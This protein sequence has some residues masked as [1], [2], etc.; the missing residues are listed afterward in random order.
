MQV[1]VERVDVREM[2]VE[3]DSLRFD[4]AD[5]LGDHPEG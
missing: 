5:L 1:V 3:N 2:L 4:L